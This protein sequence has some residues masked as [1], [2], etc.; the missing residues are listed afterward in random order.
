MPDTTRTFLAV[1][2]PDDL[3]TK[4]NRLQQQLAGEVPEARWA[5]IP[6]FHATLA[7]LGDVVDA[8]LPAVCR[9][10]ADAV[11]GFGPFELTLEGIGAFPSPARPRVVWAGVAGAGLDAL[12]QVQAAVAEA[13]AE[14][15]YPTDDKP[16]HPHVTL[17]RLKPGRGPGCDLTR[18][19]NHYK[20]WHAGP[21]AVPEV[22]TF[23]ST[24]TREGPAYAP[25]AR[26]RLAAR[27]PGPSP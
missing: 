25:L 4:L 18:L 15:H 2:V 26:A 3:N 1:A 7:F 14:A 24:L 27:K 19:V 20:T 12:R 5:M 17:G 9:A 11:A 23:A 8:D 22:V 21:F 6:P 10:A 16:F 13:V